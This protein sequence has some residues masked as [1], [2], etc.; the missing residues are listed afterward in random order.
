M[1]F[2]ILLRDSG[3]KHLNV[4]ETSLECIFSNM[5]GGVGRT[6]GCTPST[7]CGKCYSLYSYKIT[8][9]NFTKDSQ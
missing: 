7:F 8:M 3:A 6:G 9:Q 2:A 5:G 1:L 4:T